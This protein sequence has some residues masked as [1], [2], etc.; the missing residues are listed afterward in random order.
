[1]VRVLN[2]KCLSFKVTFASQLFLLKG[3][4]FLF[5]SHFRSGNWKQ[6]ISTRARWLLCIQLT[7]DSAFDYMLV[8][9][10][11]MRVEWSISCTNSFY[12]SIFQSVYCITHGKLAKVIKV[13][14]CYCH[15]VKSRKPVK[16]E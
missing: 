12:S 5:Q 16:D 11:L 10:Y 1:M 15:D 8:I 9:N 14:I 13:I 6:L 7:V 3:N 2:I 4:S